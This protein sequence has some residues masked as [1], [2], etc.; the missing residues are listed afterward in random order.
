MARIEGLDIRGGSGNVYKFN[1]YPIDSNW[2]EIGAVYAV[3][4]RTQNNIGGVFHT[5]IYVGQTGDMAE[6][7]ANHHKADCFEEHEANCICIRAEENEDTR[8]MIEADLLAGHDWT[9]NE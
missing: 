7:H 4:K 8:L 6:R 2:R 9:C 1:V 5:L 3:T